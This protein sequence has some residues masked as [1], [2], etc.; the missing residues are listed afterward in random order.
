MLRKSLWIGLTGLVCWNTALYAEQPPDSPQ[1]FLA[2]CDKVGLSEKTR[3]QAKAAATKIF[4]AAGLR[5]TWFDSTSYSSKTAFDTNS[6]ESCEV[7][8]T[9]YILVVITADK[10]KGW[11]TDLLGLSPKT[12]IFRRR[13]YI[14]YD[15][16]MTFTQDNRPRSVVLSDL[17]LLIGN[18][19]AHELGHLLMPNAGHSPAG[20]M[21]ANWGYREAAEAAA[22]TLIFG[23]DQQAMMH[24]ELHRNAAFA[25]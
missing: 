12:D 8:S 20:L 24:R 7:P 2:L 6:L 5:T 18:V 15:R 14:L 17:G 22:G 16:V 25:N 3:Q 19:I 9:S 10:P 23:S 21:R 4:D 11:T 1:V 13:T